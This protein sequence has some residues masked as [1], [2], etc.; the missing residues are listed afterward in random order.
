MNYQ[1]FF[2]RTISSYK[3][4]KLK[5]CLGKKNIPYTEF[6]KVISMVTYYLFNSVINHET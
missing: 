1:Q 6:H 5:I 2:C 3:V 4:E